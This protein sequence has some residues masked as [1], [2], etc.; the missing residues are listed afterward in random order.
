MVLII[1]KQ[2][3]LKLNYKVSDLESKNDDISLVINNQSLDLRSLNYSKNFAFYI[4]DNNVLNE[5]NKG[6]IFVKNNSNLYDYTIQY[7]LVSINLRKSKIEIDKDIPVI[8]K[9]FK[10]SLI[11]D[12]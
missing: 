12:E 4:S 1:Q 7:I 3:I 9:Y 11:S 8:S 2:E 10:L 5:N 6:I